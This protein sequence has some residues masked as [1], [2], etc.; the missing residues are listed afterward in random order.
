MNLLKHGMLW[1]AFTLMLGHTVAPH[2][3]GGVL[4]DNCSEQ[5]SSWMD[6]LQHLFH[7]DLGQHHLEDFSDAGRLFFGALEVPPGLEIPAVFAPEVQC[8]SYDPYSAVSAAGHP[9]GSYLRGP[10]MKS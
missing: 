7:P 2:Q 4:A 9:P 5:V 3:H 1:M 8:P 10:P 6:V